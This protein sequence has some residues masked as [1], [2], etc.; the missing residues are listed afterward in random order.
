MTT[1]REGRPRNGGKNGGLTQPKGEGK[2]SQAA[3]QS[4]DRAE[5]YDLIPGLVFVMDTNHTILDLNEPAAHT[6]GR[7]RE[8]CIG[9]KFW[10]LFDNPGCR[11]GTCAASEA[12]RTGKTCEGEA[13]PVVQGKEVPVLVTAAPRLDEQGRVIGVV[14]LVFPAAGDV[15]LARETGRLAAAAREGRLGER[16]DESKFQG[17]H[18]E[19]AKAL[20]SML[21]VI[22][23]PIQEA[24]TVLAQIADGDLT[25]RVVGDYTGDHG[26]IKNHIKLMAD[27]LAASMQ[28]IGQ[29]SQTLA[30]SSEELSAVSQQMSSNAEETSAQA[31]VVAA[32]AEQ[33]TKNLQTVATATEEM[34][35]SIKEIAKNASEAAKVA[36]SAVKIAENTNATVAKL[37]TSSAEIGKVIKVITSI[38]QQTNLLALNATI[39]AARAGEA[40]KG[41]AV[42]ANEVK[43][44][45]KETAKATEEITQKI[46]S[47]QGNTKGAVEAIAQISQVIAQINDISNTIAGAVEEQTA[48][49]NEMA[50]NVSEA[51]QGGRQVAENITSVATAAK[52]TSS[53]ASE[54]QSAS[55]ELSR[56]AA[57]LQRLVGQFKFEGAGA[58][59]VH[60]S[61]AKQRHAKVA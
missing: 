25:A 7:K 23:K 38:A 54:T 28:S 60:S 37:G 5:I 47:I 19:R 10:D 9:A 40:G 36:T 26:E 41:F 49:T 58:A 52:N 30:S 42:V 59:V 16:I 50:R 1:S 21:D 8:D 33:V 22:V 61:A 13:L 18:L 14:E 15:G 44:L 17:R 2:V 57:E 34:T 51:A 46:E 31:G 20:N 6:A 4:M 45:A 39:E 55:G 3:T 35:A 29:N 48:T 27:K 32:A 12:V 43:E 11:A 24:G 56:M 53:G